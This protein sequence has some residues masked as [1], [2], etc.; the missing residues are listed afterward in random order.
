MEGC[1]KRGVGDDSMELGE[2]GR[3]G[4][5]LGK[6]RRTN[7]CS[8]GGGG[9]GGGGMSVG[10][11]GGRGGPVPTPYTVQLTKSGVQRQRWRDLFNGDLS[12]HI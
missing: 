1:R 7:C 10:D 2:G 6:G 8:K 9:R 3:R 5:G 11:G 4:R 12:V